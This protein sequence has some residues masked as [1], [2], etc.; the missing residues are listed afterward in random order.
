MTNYKNN[1]AKSNITTAKLH[2]LF[3]IL[4]QSYTKKLLHHNDIIII[5]TYYIAINTKCIIIHTE[6]LQSSIGYVYPYIDCPDIPLEAV[7]KT[8]EAVR[9]TL[10]AVRKTF[11]AV[12]I[13]LEAVC[14]SLEAVCKSLEKFCISLD[15]IYSTSFDIN[16][17][18]KILCYS[19][20]GINAIKDNTNMTKNAI[21]Y[22]TMLLNNVLIIFY[23]IR[24]KVYTTLFLFNVAI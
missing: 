1:C 6:R 5:Y 24:N 10:E 8:F 17:S 21:K 15:E 20:E 23:I 13:S 12:R 18:K 2:K 11:E 19:S 7:R 3:A 22:V 14:I 9:K 16:A 4:Q